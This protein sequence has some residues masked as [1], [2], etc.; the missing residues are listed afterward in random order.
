MPKLIRILAVGTIFSGAAAALSVLPSGATPVGG[1][2][3]VVEPVYATAGG[4]VYVTGTDKNKD[5]TGFFG[6]LCQ[7]A[8]VWVT[9]TYYTTSEAL[10]TVTTVIG[11]AEDIAGIPQPVTIPADAEPT[12]IHGQMAQVH[13]FCQAGT[14]ASPTTYVSDPESV[15]VTGTGT[16]PAPTTTT[17]T[18]ST[19]STTTTTTTTTTAPVIVVATNS[20]PTAALPAAASAPE[21]AAATTPATP[22]AA[23]QLAQ[24]GSDIALNLWLGGSLVVLGSLLVAL[25]SWRRRQARRFHRG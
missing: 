6:T 5:D 25:D 2:Q 8:T 13:A 18:T 16:R 7:D 23:T 11:K 24:T 12:R 15:T 4:A 9:V 3:I 22:T 14:P 10:A 21:E 19:T 20:T 1:Y 17:T